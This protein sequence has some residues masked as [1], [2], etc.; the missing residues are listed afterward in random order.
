M[1]QHWALQMVIVTQLPPTRYLNS[2]MHK[3][4]VTHFT[5][6]SP[7]TKGVTIGIKEGSHIQYMGPTNTITHQEPYNI[8]D[9][10]KEATERN[11]KVPKDVQQRKPAIGKLYAG[12][13]GGIQIEIY[14]IHHLVLEIVLHIPPPI[15][16]EVRVTATH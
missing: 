8:K 11:L 15:P 5:S 16:E 6:T 9:T 3:N 10:N 12:V 7:F 4:E 14:L 1:E 13:M 2:T